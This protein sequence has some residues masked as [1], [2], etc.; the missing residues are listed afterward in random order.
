MTDIASL[1]DKLTRA[2]LTA[3]Q[4]VARRLLATLCRFV[5]DKADPPPAP[6]SRK[7]S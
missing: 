4:P 3:L 2:D 7:A 5:A 1:V 6:R